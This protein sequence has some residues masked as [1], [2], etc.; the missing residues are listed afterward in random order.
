MSL[1]Q[2]RTPPE[3]LG[4]VIGVHRVVCWGALP[5]GAF[6][7]GAV[8]EAW[9]LRWAVAACGLAVLV[10]WLASTP[11]LIRSRPDSYTITAH[12]D[13]YGAQAADG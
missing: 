2:S 5:L 11:L 3:M 12:P 8:G 4:R 9:G 6:G 1:R 7:A 10:T 13:S